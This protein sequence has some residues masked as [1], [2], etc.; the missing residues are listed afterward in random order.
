MPFKSLTHLL[1]II[2]MGSLSQPA[3]A[4]EFLDD[5][6][7]IKYTK[8]NYEASKFL[9]SFDT[10]ITLSKKP[11]S[12]AVNGLV[13]PKDNNA[14][15]SESGFIYMV[16]TDSTFFGK[17]STYTS[18]FSEN[19][20]VLQKLRELRG[21]KNN[22]KLY[23]FAQNGKYDFRK[24]F[25]NENYVIDLG[26]VKNWGNS[27]AA[28]PTAVNEGQVVS[29]SSALLYLVS[30]LKL[31]NPGDETNLILYSS[32]QLINTRLVVQ[33]KIR[34][35]ADFNIVSGSGS[36][37]F[38]GKRDAIKILVEPVDS[39]GRPVKDLEIMGLEG[40]ISMYIDEATRL[41]LQLS[42]KVEVAGKVNIKLKQAVSAD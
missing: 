5:Q 16:S 41:L 17:H 39:Q 21:K 4:L 31:R 19:A 22:G 26:E 40:D 2:F 24:N 37:R 25:D 23:R 18:W 29:E 13:T 30:Q 6:R 7:N 3:I 11:L 10:D 33:E 32:G 38:N 9:L 15:V 36:Q 42:G 28:Y 14:L 1:L 27:F 20:A 8:L 34:L 35:D 12:E